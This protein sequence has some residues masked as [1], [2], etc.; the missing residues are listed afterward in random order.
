MTRT[1]GVAV[2]YGCR[3]DP[4][5]LAVASGHEEAVRER[6]VVME[7]LRKA[8][9]VRIIRVI[10]GQDAGAAETLRRFMEDGEGLAWAECLPAERRVDAFSGE[11]VTP[12]ISDDPVAELLL[13]SGD[14]LS[15]KL[16][17]H[18]ARDD[19]VLFGEEGLVAAG[20]RLIAARKP[21]AEGGAPA[22]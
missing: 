21:A 1:V 18:E 15:R 13:R 6:V 10:L 22:P 9:P 17:V 19:L 14:H 8:R 3:T 2:L 5:A 12:E 20:E 11:T 7:G 4:L 16:E